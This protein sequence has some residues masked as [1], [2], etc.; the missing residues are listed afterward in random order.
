MD[1]EAGVSSFSVFPEKIDV[2]TISLY[3]PQFL[4]FLPTNGVVH[5]PAGSSLVPAGTTAQ[6]QATYWWPHTVKRM[7]WP[8]HSSSPHWSQSVST[9]H[10]PLSYF[11]ALWSLIVILP[12]TSTYSAAWSICLSVRWTVL[13]IEAQIH[14]SLHTDCSNSQEC[15]I[16]HALFVLPYITMGFAAQLGGTPCADV[17]GWDRT[18]VDAR[19]R[20]LKRCLISR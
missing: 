9:A 20:S 1:L 12:H 8:W 18:G 7:P 19:W 5:S 17:R 16:Q 15:H 10:P 2:T 4:S 6:L 13:E 3:L 14:T 11:S